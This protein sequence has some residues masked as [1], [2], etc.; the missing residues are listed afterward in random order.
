M[1]CLVIVATKAEIA[2]KNNLAAFGINQIGKYLQ[3][4]RAGFLH[5]DEQGLFGILIACQRQQARGRFGLTSCG[6]FSADPGGI[7]QF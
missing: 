7:P 4:Q 1:P 2:A 3:D 5:D 6:Y